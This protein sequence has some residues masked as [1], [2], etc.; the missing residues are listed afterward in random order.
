MSDSIC[1]A[2]CTAPSMEGPAP[3][4]HSLFISKAKS[5][6]MR[7][8]ATAPLRDFCLFS[9]YLMVGQLPYLSFPLERRVYLC[10]MTQR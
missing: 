2:Y 4:S 3:G 10:V 5:A 8:T 6:L 9:E 7:S 1:T